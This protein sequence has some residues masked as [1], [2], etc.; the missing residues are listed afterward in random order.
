LG[1][2]QTPIYERSSART[3]DQLKD[4]NF[5][6][7]CSKPKQGNVRMVAVV[8]CAAKSILDKVKAEQSS[9]SASL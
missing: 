7:S 9:E 8:F 3:I 4:Q 1:V 5:A 2:C 6:A